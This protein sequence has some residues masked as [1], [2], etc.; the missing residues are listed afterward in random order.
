MRYL[1]RVPEDNNIWQ[2]KKM[3]YHFDMTLIVSEIDKK[4]Q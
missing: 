2:Q 4:R 3:S 1:K